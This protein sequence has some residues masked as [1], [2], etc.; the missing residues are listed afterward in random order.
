MTTATGE[1]FVISGLSLGTPYVGQGVYALRLIE[2]LAKRLGKGLVVVTST[3][4]IDPPRIGE[5]EFVALSPSWKSHQKIVDRALLSNHLLRFV[6]E[7]YPSAIFHS[8]GPIVGLTKPATTVVTLHDCIYRHFPQYNGRLFFRRVLANCTE[9]FAASASLVL[10]DSE[11]SRKDLIRRARIPRSKLRVLY[12][13]VGNEFL[14]TIPSEEI[15]LVRQ[16]FKLP[17]RF[18]LYLGGY[19]YRKNVE[20]LLFSYALAARKRQLP[21]LVLAGSIPARRHQSHCDVE[22]AQREAGLTETQVLKPGIIPASDL[23][24]LYRAAGLLIYPSLMEGFGLPPA[25]A[26]AVGTPV[27]AS[28]RSSLPEV[29]RKPECRF[30]PCDREALTEKLLAAA[31][32]EGQFAAELS[33]TF[34]EEHGIKRYL[35]LLAEVK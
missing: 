28:N 15:E 3:D 14:R 23:P 19:D 31:E 1:R 13:W 20:F 30:D 4:I 27:L 6:R 26:M 25:E 22:G 35:E 16:R 11:F 32:N 17:R 7:H 18:W 21:P 33:S 29:V 2:G 10:T 9:R 24:A 5:A 12:P 8:P 34:T